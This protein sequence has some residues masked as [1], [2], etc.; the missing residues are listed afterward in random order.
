MNIIELLNNYK[1]MQTFL[2]D[3]T[4]IP[5]AFHTC[6][7]FAHLKLFL[8]CYP[9]KN[10]NKNFFKNYSLEFSQGDLEYWKMKAN[11]QQRCQDSGTNTPFFP[12]N[13]DFIS[14]NSLL[15]I[16]SHS[17]VILNC[18]LLFKFLCHF[19]S[20]CFPPTTLGHFERRK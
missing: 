16:I 6:L 8:F 18:F 2:F 5:S 12:F 11:G 9:G 4:F 13:F 14:W 15:G 7:E 10:E 1:N 19:H 3:K 17:C 20:V